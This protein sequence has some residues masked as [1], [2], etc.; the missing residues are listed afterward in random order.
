VTNQKAPNHDLLAGVVVVSLAINLPGPLTA[1]RLTKLGAHVTTVLP[2]SGD[3]LKNYDPQWFADL[4]AGQEALTLDLKSPSGIT[5]LDSLLASADLLITSS[6]PSALTRLGL[7]PETVS[8]K[9]PRL[10]Q[11]AIVGESG[12]NAENPGHDLTYQAI[13]GLIAPPA[14]PTSLIADMAGSERA[15]QIAIAALLHRE[16]TGVA[17]HH[18]VA[19]ADV[20]HDMAEPNR[21]GL[22]KPSGGLG[23]AIGLYGIYETQDGWVA[24]AALEPHFAQRTLQALDVDGSPAGFAQV[25]TAKTATQWEH[26][27]SEKD[28]PLV[29]LSH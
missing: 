13:N 20:A 15:T 21:R 9:H 28:I 23:G 26:W 8:T 25:F 29:A 17:T 27:A 22:T 24:L 12:A 4:H 5:E 18:Q 3:P 14:M 19:L 11:V 16:R 6:R 1:A 2:P 7:D 10:C